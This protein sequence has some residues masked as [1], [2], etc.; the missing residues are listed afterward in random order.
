MAPDA[1][2]SSASTVGE[3]GEQ[4]GVLF[5][6]LGNSALKPERS[7]EFE[8]GIDGTFLRVFEYQVEREFSGPDDAWR[9]VFVNIRPARAFQL[10]AG[11]FKIPFSREQ[12]TGTS[13]LDFVYRSLAATYLAPGRDRG[14]T[15]IRTSCAPCR[16]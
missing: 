7:T 6:V 5:S 2:F 12:L 8:V 3:S 10:Q 13:S 15:G 4:S 1:Y 9:D 14:S 16:S 11:A